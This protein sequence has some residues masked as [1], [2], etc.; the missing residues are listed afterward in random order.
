MRDAK[1]E[2]RY[3]LAV[4]DLDGTLLDTSEGIYEAAQH[5]ARRFGRTLPGRESLAQ[6]IGPPIQD[7]FHI[8]YGVSGAE[9]QNMAD[10]F[11][12]QYATEDLYKAS[13]YDGIYDLLD[14]I[15]DSGIPVCIATYKREDYAQQIARHFGLDA[16]ASV[17]YGA[18]NDNRYTKTDILRRVLE[19]AKVQP[20]DAVMVGD[21]SRDAQAA[22][23]CGV[24]F[25]AVTYGYGFKGEEDRNLAKYPHTGTAGT[26]AEILQHILPA[27]AGKAHADAEQAEADTDADLPE[28]ADIYEAR[29]EEPGIA[30]DTKD[31]ADTTVEADAGT[32]REETKDTGT[33][34]TQ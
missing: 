30:A 31:A 29:T 4:F 22:M 34:D 10:A 15:T 20:A 17:V 5:T 32:H 9:L 21:S 25:I 19:H 16:Y 18:D 33:A 3:S 14:K 28:A 24:D 12:T 27:Y 6:L 1:E 23:E 13:P 7:S 26:P 2:K 11:R 8:L